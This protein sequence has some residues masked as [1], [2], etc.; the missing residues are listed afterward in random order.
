MSGIN[1]LL[2][3]WF[4]SRLPVVMGGSLA[5]VLPVMSIINDYNDQ[6][7][8]SEQEVCLF[9]NISIVISTIGVF[10]DMSINRWSESLIDYDTCNL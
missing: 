1:T 2:Q 10:Y 4:G 5:F 8:S 9:Q 6:T 3:T 7:F